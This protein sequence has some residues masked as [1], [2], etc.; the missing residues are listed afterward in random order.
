MTGADSTGLLDNFSSAL[1]FS[2]EQG[3]NILQNAN[4][5]ASFLSLVV[6]KK[7]LIP[8]LDIFEA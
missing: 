6:N 3:L 5:L 2:Y 4:A 1:C 8:R 7:K